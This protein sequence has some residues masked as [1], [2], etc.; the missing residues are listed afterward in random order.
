MPA[1]ATPGTKENSDVDMDATAAA[2]GQEDGADSEASS[3]WDDWADAMIG[4]GE[5]PEA[6]SASPAAGDNNNGHT[7]I[8]GQAKEEAWVRSMIQ[9]G[10]LGSVVQA[11]DSHA[12]DHVLQ[13]AVEEEGEDAQWSYGEWVRGRRAMH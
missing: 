5:P 7:E 8:D 12:W 4:Q 1:L 13:M 6:P 10:T 11:E 2:D 9:Q 3:D